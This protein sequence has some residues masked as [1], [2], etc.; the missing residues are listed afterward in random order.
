[1]GWETKITKVHT[2]YCNTPGCENLNESDMFYKKDAEDVF[3]SLGW[4]FLKF[5]HRC[6]PCT[7]RIIRG[8]E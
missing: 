3:K 1:M 8:D 2:I 6:P 4:T 7:L 5:G